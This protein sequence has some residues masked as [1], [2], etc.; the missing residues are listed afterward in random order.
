MRKL[1]I[2]SF[3]LPLVAGCGGAESPEAG[4]DTETA[5]AEATTDAAR[6][7]LAGLTPAYLEGDWCYE[8]YRAGEETEE[9]GETYRFNADGTLL[10][11]NNPT[12]PVD[13]EGRWEV[14]DGKF[15]IY[16]TL[17]FLPFRGA[18][19]EDDA[20]TLEGSFGQH[21][22]SRGACA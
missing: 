11:Q 4:D 9:V 5:S 20:M 19:L 2:L 7:G 18:T 12:T 13:R 6:G 17:E 10:Y 8:S 16:P 15:T 14:A 3:A 1:F 21:H 22:W